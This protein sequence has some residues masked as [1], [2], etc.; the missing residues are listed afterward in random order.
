VSRNWRS[1]VLRLG[2]TFGT[3]WIGFLV[4]LNPW[5]RVEAISITD[6]L[7]AIGAD[8][9]RDGYANQ[10]LVIP[11]SERPFLATISPSCS[12]VAAVL[13][14]G[15]V[16]MFLVSGPAH[17]RMLAFLAASAV[18]ISC[19]VLRIAAS[20]FVGIQTGAS[21]LVVFHD[22]VGTILG[23]VG[24]LGGFVVFVFLQLPSTKTL[25]EEATRAH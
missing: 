7:H 17:R 8:R 23:L 19:N 9:V 18:V 14:F 6:V 25:L 16:A 3:V 2:L 24:L 10:I 15:A 21:G 11:W 22:W 13:A 4:L 20:I 1:V 12:A 5:R